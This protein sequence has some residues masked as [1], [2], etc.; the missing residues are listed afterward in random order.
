MIQ[1]PPGESVAA[2]TT[3]PKLLEAAQRAGIT[4][5]AQIA[6]ILPTGE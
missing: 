3:V 4:V 5:R 2:A 6:Y 1:V